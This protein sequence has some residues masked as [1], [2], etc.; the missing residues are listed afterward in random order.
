M[1]LQSFDFNQRSIAS[2][3]SHW[4]TGKTFSSQGIL[5]RLETE[6]KSHKIL[7]NSGNFRQMLFVIFND[8]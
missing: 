3:G 1:R 7:G 2:E 6:G 4:K 8:I 5:K